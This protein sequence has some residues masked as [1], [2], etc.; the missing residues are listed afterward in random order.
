MIDNYEEIR[1][2]V[3]KYLPYGANNEIAREFK[4]SRKW[5]SELYARIRVSGVRTGKYQD[6]EILA[7]M[8]QIVDQRLSLLNEK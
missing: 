2:K 7:R 8:N 6:A 3:D 1:Q 4:Q 5:K